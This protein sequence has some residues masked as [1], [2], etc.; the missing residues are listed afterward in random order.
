MP[1][2]SSAENREID[3]RDAT[4]EDAPAACKVLSGRFGIVRGRPSND[5]AILDRWLANKTRDRRVMDYP[6]SNSMLVAVE[7]KTI[8]RLVR[9]PMPGRSHST[10]SRR[11]KV[12]WRHRAMLRALEARAVERGISMHLPAARR[13]GG[14]NRS[15]GMSRSSSTGYVWRQAIH[16]KAV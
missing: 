12:S 16:V 10:T 4:P 2:L 13:R 1:R 9:S 8:S 14:F 3:I 15:A 7:G 5:P 6:A 11:R